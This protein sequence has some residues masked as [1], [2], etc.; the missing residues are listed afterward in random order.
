MKDKNILEFLKESNYI[1]DERSD[2]ALEDSIEAWS[3][4]YKNR[5][6]IDNIDLDYILGIHKRLAQRIDPKIAGK[7]RDCDVF[8]GGHRKIFVSEALLKEELRDVIT[9]MN[10]NNFDE[11]KEEEFTKH[12]HVM[13]EHIHPFR[14]INGRSGR[15][16]YNIHRL[17][18]GLPVHIIH[19]G[20]EQ[21]KYYEWFS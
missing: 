4:A 8:I 14:D 20:K 11:G 6:N 3:Y 19:T 21:H 17:R 18:L 7:L 15:I 9:T 1:E 16:L 13:F 12:C 5:N 10:A 2:I